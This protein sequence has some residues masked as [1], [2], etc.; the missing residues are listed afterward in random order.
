VQ[1]NNNVFYLPFHPVYVAN[2]VIAIKRPSAV[3]SMM[4]LNHRII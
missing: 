4:L 1:E 2:T 3:A